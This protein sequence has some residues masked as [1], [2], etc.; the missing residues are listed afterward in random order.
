MKHD[1]MDFRVKF[2]KSSLKHPLYKL[3]YMTI[4]IFQNTRICSL[5]LHDKKWTKARIYSCRA[6]DGPETKYILLKH[7]YHNKYSNTNI[8]QFK[9]QTCNH[10]LFSSLFFCFSLELSHSTTKLFHLPFSTSIQ[11]SIRSTITIFA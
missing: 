10:I 6:R 3:S 5:K 1:Y 7:E 2:I 9:T 8:Q 4:L 11:D